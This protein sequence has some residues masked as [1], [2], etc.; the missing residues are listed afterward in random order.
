MSWLYL[1]ALEEGF[2]PHNGLK[3]GVQSVMSKTTPTVLK[4]S[5]RESETVSCMMPL[6]GVILEHSTGD[7]GVDAWIL[8]LQASRAN[9][10][11]LQ[12]NDEQ[13][14][15]LEMDGMTPFALLRKFS[16]NM[17]SSKMYGDC[18]MQWINPQMNLFHTWERFSRSW[19]K[20]GMMQG[21]VCFRRRKWE[22]RIKEIGS[23]LLPITTA[24]EMGSNT[25]LRRRKL[26][27]KQAI[28][29][30]R[31]PSAGDA[32]RGWNSTDSNGLPHLTAQVHLFPTPT[33][34]GNGNKKGSSRKA[35]DGLETFVKRYPTPTVADSKNNGNPS[36]KERM[37]PGL[38]GV[39]GGR[40]N[41]MWVEWL[42]GLPI[43]WS[44]LEPLAMPKFQEWLKK[45]GIC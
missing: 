36:R 38:N 22:L 13:M 18:C 2:L 39:I 40:L 29:M 24:S 26:T 25:T 30:W 4:S 10:L 5:N 21:G 41:P 20:A 37:S 9:H 6:S 23:G 27:A 19:H 34:S 32:L 11:V 15:T 42:M 31:S 28:L 16:L 3:N 33:V 7:H 43:G 44:G 14:M 35:G 1:P 8:S 17:Y 12:E 45:H